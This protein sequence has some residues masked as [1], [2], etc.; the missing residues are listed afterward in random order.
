MPRAALVALAMLATGSAS[1]GARAQAPQRFVAGAD[2]VLVDVLVTRDGQPV[3][4]LTAADFIVTDNGVEQTAQLADLTSLPVGLLFV[5]DTSGSLAGPP[6]EHLKAAAHAALDNLRP[7][8]QA[9][10]MVFS[11]SLTLVSGWTAD[12]AQMARAIDGVTARGATSL[13]DA[14]FAALALGRPAGFRPLLLF[15]SDGDDTASWLPAT[16]PVEAARRSDAVVYV[17]SADPAGAATRSGTLAAPQVI[18]ERLFEQPSLYRDALL[19]VLARETGGELVRVA[20]AASLQTV[21][22][23]AV[24]RFNQRYVLGYTPTGVPPSG[25]HDLEVSV[26]TPGLEVVARRGYRR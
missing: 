14:A 11:Q 9:A 6:L 1:G 25:W 18:Q 22:A 23:N 20:D 4:G 24:S 15:F 12:R 13:S 19:P 26:R 16:T 5:L 2:V 3:S 17:V 21:F 8:D 7:A 10:L